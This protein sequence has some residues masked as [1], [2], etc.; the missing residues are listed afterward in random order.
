VLPVGTGDSYNWF[1]AVLDLSTGA[2]TRIP[3]KY[4][5]DF[6]ALAWTH[7]GRVLGTGLGLQ[8]ALWKFEQMK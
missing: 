6:H 1:P 7:D 4:A 3:L 2:L 5:T 8:S